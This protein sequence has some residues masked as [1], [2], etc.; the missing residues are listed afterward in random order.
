M[1]LKLFRPADAEINTTAAMLARLI[2]VERTAEHEMLERRLSAAR[3]AR[4]SLAQRV[5]AEEF[6]ALPGTTPA[7]RQARADLA[8]HEES[9]ISTRHELIPHRQRYGRRYREAADPALK[10]AASE[11]IAAL[12]T[13]DEAVKLL[14]EL[15]RSVRAAHGPA[16]EAI[17]TGM[18]TALRMVLK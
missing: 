16:G 13:L 14:N 10:A 7:L 18:I 17:P 11:A 5:Q 9:I 8:A 2:K 1:K 3:K 12:D 4:P 15:R 6:A